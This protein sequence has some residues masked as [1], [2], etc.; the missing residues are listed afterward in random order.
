MGKNLETKFIGKKIIEFKTINSTNTYL[1][2]IGNIENEGTVVIS[3]EQTG[4]RGRL[5]R[6]WVSSHGDGIYMSML[7]K[8]KIKVEKSPFITIIAGAS[9]VKALNDFGINAMIKWPNDIVINGKKICGILTELN[10]HMEKINYIVLGIGINIKKLDFEEDI[11]NM[12]TSIYKEGYE[13][14]RKDLFNSILYEFENL[15]LDYIKYDEKNEVLNICRKYSAIINK[16][17]YIVNNN[18]K[19]LAFC[20]D[21][22]DNGNLLVKVNDN[23][24]EISSTEVS[25]RGEDCYI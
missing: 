17:V 15:Y 4:G 5:G 24:I 23:I 13:I 20:I 6:R 3:E 22:N 12:A 1:K 21:I 7:L 25:I 11:K 16:K 2:E 18:K 8:P 9:I 10:S 19:E 14:S